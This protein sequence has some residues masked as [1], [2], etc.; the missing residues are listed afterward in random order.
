M[1]ERRAKLP[2][3]SPLARTGTQQWAR[4]KGVL[5]KDQDFK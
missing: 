1:A 3:G 2:L 5:V 4:E